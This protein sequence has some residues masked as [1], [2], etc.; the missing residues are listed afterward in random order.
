MQYG[1][2]CLLIN[3]FTAS[4]GSGVLCFT[5]CFADYCQLLP[6]LFV[7]IAACSWSFVVWWPFNIAHTFKITF[8]CIPSFLYILTQRANATVVCFLSCARPVYNL[9]EIHLKIK[10]WVIQ[11]SHGTSVFTTSRYLSRINRFYR[12]SASVKERNAWDFAGI[13]HVT[14]IRT[15]VKEASLTSNV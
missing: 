8:T 12:G 2:Y 13:R 11:A 14:C 5:Q 6:F 4:K 3:V 7:I 10:C 1:P 15:P 9:A